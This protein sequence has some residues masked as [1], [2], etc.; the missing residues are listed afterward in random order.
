MK[1]F[2]AFTLSYHYPQMMQALSL[3]PEKD[4]VWPH[5]QA[6]RPIFAGIDNLFIP[7]MI[8]EQTA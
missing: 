2:P 8:N 6:K 3:M 4:G 7:L 1:S 5:R